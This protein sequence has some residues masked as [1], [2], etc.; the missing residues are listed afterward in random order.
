M[1]S[2][3]RLDHALQR[4]NSP[5]LRKKFEH[6]LEKIKEVTGI[7]MTEFGHPMDHFR[8]AQGEAL[9]WGTVREFSIALGSLGVLA[10]EHSLEMDK[11]TPAFFQRLIN[12]ALDR[13]KSRTAPGRR[14]VTGKGEMPL[15]ITRTDIQ[16][17]ISTLQKLLRDGELT[18]PAQERRAELRIT[19][20]REGW[21]GQV[22]AHP[23]TLST[24]ERRTFPDGLYERAKARAMEGAISSCQTVAVRQGGLRGQIVAAGDD[25]AEDEPQPT[26]RRKEPH[27][28]KGV[29]VSDDVEESGDEHEAQIGVLREKGKRSRGKTLMADDSD[30]SDGIRGCSRWRKKHRPSSSAPSFV[31]RRAGREEERSDEGNSHTL[32]PVQT[33]REAESQGMTEGERRGK[34]ILEFLPRSTEPVHRPLQMAETSPR[35]LLPQDVPNMPVQA[36]A[37]APVDS[38]TPAER[39]LPQASGRMSPGD[40]FSETGGVVYWPRPPESR[41]AVSSG[42]SAETL[43]LILRRIKR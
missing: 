38:P 1:A 30:L 26:V 10:Q 11:L 34:R 28:L 25:E 20:R 36:S 27:P 2:I 24:L 16:G 7:D 31:Q 18:E 32:S 14:N 9:P 15:K 21:I 29:P 12:T 43:E 40:P 3:S 23:L 6:E 42:I 41:R 5:L 33:R 19:E 8:D 4:I 39:Q 37:A 17:C 13:I 35:M 22:T